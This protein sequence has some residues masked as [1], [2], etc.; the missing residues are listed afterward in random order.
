MSDEE[1]ASITNAIWLCSDCHGLIDKDAARYSD[2]L[3]LIWKEKHEEKLLREIGKPGELLRRLANDLELGTL[4]KMPLYAEQIVR[5]RPTYWEF[6]LTAELLDFHLKP[7]LRSARDLQLGLV[8][9]PKKLL[10]YDDFLR[11]LCSKP[12][13][14]M[15]FASVM[16]GLLQELQIAWGKPGEPGD[17]EQIAHVTDLFGRAAQHLI[18]CAEEV[19]FTDVPDGFQGVSECIVEGALHPIKKLPELTVFIRSIFQTSTTPGGEHNFVV[20]IDL[21]EGWEDR[22]E[23]ELANGSAALIARRGEW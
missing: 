17:A 5:D 12:H 2:S 16:T 6:M 11:W 10:P 13:D 9:K 22:F 20:T 19:K 18:D 15:L 3:L 14:L 4:G 23:R 7:V 8:A 21:P 1:R